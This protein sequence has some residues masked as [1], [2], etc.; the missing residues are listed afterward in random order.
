MW[1]KRRLSHI[2]PLLAMASPPHKMSKLAHD[3]AKDAQAPILQ[4]S[5][6]AES[7]ASLLPTPSKG[8]RLGLTS[9]VDKSK[10]KRITLKPKREC[11]VRLC[12]SPETD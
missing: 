2:S 10:V 5:K 3:A 6:A 7:S 12:R 11:S 4:S 8:K 9:G 1:S